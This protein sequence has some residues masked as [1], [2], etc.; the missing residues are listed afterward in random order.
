M[1]EPGC[2][3]L[4]PAPAPDPTAVSLLPRVECA[5][6]LTMHG[7]ERLPRL[8]RADCPLYRL[9]TRT[10]LQINRGYRTCPKSHVT[11]T[12]YDLTHAYAEVARWTRGMGNVLIME[13]DAQIMPGA[14]DADFALVDDFVATR[15]F[16]VYSLGSIGPF[17]PAGW[18]S[19]HRM[20]V[21]HWG[22][23]QAIIWSPR[24]REELLR[25]AAH[26]LPMH[27]DGSFLAQL[28]RCF[29]LDRPLVVQTF[30]VTANS[31]NWCFV[32]T[33]GLVGRVDRAAS[34]LVHATMGRFGLDHSVH[35]WRALYAFNASALPVLVVVCLAVV[36]A[37]LLS[38]LR[39]RR[40][41][42]KDSGLVIGNPPPL[43]FESAALPEGNSAVTA[44]VFCAP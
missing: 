6:V 26:R 2:Y 37:L 13:D 35:G 8:Q 11:N 20:F 43:S 21:N 39:L 3:Q 9:C 19:R 12:A 44:R 15:E 22:I 33:G 36:A 32:C 7:S 18:G 10:L 40:R 28:P 5:V 38:A 23:T 41:L 14:T 16:D 4:E 1:T 25:R 31:S 17:R 24:A 42:R 30:P 34:R 27:I 29:T